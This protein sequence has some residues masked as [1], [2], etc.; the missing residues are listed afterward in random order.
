MNKCNND[1]KSKNNK[2][3]NNIKKDSQNYPKSTP[4]FYQQMLGLLLVQ[5]SMVSQPGC[6]DMTDRK[7][8]SATPVRDLWCDNASVNFYR[9]INVVGQ[10]LSMEA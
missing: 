2:M 3:Y 6:L 5:V 9:G 4:H 7:L 10:N 8:K 1:E